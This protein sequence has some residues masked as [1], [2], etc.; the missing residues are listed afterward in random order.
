MTK[1]DYLSKL[2]L[3]GCLNDTEITS[4][5]YKEFLGLKNMKNWFLSDKFTIVNLNVFDLVFKEKQYRINNE[6]N[7]GEYIVVVFIKNLEYDTSCNLGEFAIEKDANE[8]I[9]ALYK[10]LTSSQVVEE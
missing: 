3:I 5:N 10:K 2:G 4:K 7:E 6:T 1:L 8:Y 9:A